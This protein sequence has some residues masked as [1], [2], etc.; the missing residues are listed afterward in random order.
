M[1][2]SKDVGEGDIKT[3]LGKVNKVCVGVPYC[4][5]LLTRYTEQG[6]K[7]PHEIKTLMDKHDFYFV[8]LSCSFLPD[9]NCRFVWARF[10]IELRVKSGSEKQEKPIAHDMFPD[11]VVTEMKYK[12]KVVFGPG[13]K[14]GLG[15]L[16]AGVT[17]GVETEKDVTVYVPQMFAFGINRSNVAWDFTSIEGKG[18]W[19]NKRDLLLVVRSPKDSVL[20]GRFLLGAEVEFKVL[21]VPVSKRE[22]EIVDVE[23]DLSG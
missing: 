18:I 2:K 8:D 12:R 13:L 1:E 4:E 19:G 22:D 20:C 14:L 10:G 23:Y 7:V 11:E 15:V 6:K 9:I 17:T 5:D 21:K 3:F 16:D